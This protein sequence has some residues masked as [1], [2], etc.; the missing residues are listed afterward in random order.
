MGPE[1][2]GE[3]GGVVWM[4]EDGVVVAPVLIA[5][6]VIPQPLRE[7]SSLAR[8][9]QVP[10][11]VLRLLADPFLTQGVAKPDEL[12]FILHVPCARDIHTFKIGRPRSMHSPSTSSLSSTH[13]LSVAVY[14][15]DVGYFDGSRIY[16]H[17]PNLA[18]TTVKLVSDWRQ[19]E[20]TLRFWHPRI[21][22]RFHSPLVDPFNLAIS[23]DASW[24]RVAERVSER[25]KPIG[26]VDSRDQ[27]EMEEACRQVKAAG[28]TGRLIH[29]RTGGTG[30]MLAVSGT[31]GDSFDLS[32]L[33]ADYADYLALDPALADDVAAELERLAPLEFSSFDFGR[34]EVEFLPGEGLKRRA[35]SLA[36][37]GLLLG[38]PIASTAALILGDHG[39]PGGYTRY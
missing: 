37:C 20:I 21:E 5:R 19:G 30:A 38:Y 10:R 34:V 2:P 12:R 22:A 18:E 4:D 39:L 36:R 1:T 11:G 25:L 24:H 14:L 26:F 29:Y 28:A 8:A 35:G 3:L 33:A 6:E 9:G 16:R 27:N 31:I 23:G 15:R 32:A 13:D 7:Q 17:G